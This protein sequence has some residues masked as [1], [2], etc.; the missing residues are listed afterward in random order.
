MGTAFSYRDLKDSKNGIFQGLRVDGCGFCLYSKSSGFAPVP[1][2]DG[3]TI[4]RPSIRTG[5]N[6]P[7]RHIRHDLPARWHPAC[8]GLGYEHGFARLPGCE[9]CRGP[10][11]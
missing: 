3:M 7:D 8:L 6:P 2:R 1:F 4:E 11:L 10:W 5:G 9:S